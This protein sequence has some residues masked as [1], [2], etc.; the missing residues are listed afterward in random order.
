MLWGKTHPRPLN[1]SLLHQAKYPVLTPEYK[2]SSHKS[3]HSHDHERSLEL[4][5]KTH[6]LL[7]LE[8][9]PKQLPSISLLFESCINFFLTRSFL[10]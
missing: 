8:F 4:T 3:G 1:Y 10:V 6:L 9:L 5:K 7:H 2:R